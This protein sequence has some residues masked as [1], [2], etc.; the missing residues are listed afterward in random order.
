MHTLDLNWKKSAIL[1][2]SSYKD[3]G[4]SLRGSSYKKINKVPEGARN[5]I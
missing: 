4:L 5:R 1:G 3:L 2:G